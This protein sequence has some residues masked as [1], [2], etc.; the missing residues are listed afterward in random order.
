MLP[1]YLSTIEQMNLLHGSNAV[2][3]AIVIL[4]LK[5]SYQTSYFPGKFLVHLIML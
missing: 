1:Y 2:T 3:H 5:A 4:S